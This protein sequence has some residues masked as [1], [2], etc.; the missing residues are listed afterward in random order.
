MVEDDRTDSEADDDA[1]FQLAGEAARRIVRR[2]SAHARITNKALPRYTGEPAASSPFAIDRASALAGKHPAAFAQTAKQV[3]VLSNAMTSH[4]SGLHV[5][6]QHETFHGLPAVVIARSIA[7]AAASCAWILHPGVSS[8]QRA[9]RA[10]AVMFHS[11]KNSASQVLPEDAE[12]AIKMREALVDELAGSGVTV[13][14]REKR[15]KRTDDIAQVTVGDA[16]V[17]TEYVISQRIANEIPKLRGTYGGMSSVAHGEALNVSNVWT[18]PD[19][20][21]RIIGRVAHESVTAWSQALHGWLALEPSPIGNE[22]DLQRLRQSMHPDTIAAI[23]ARSEQT[24]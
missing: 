1:R 9:A 17:K 2:C 13:T 11:L 19:L 22:D 10:Y 8:D 14:R 16:H 7:E 5:L 24:A 3:E 15:G 21:A 18:R 6:I 12:Y 4:L 20:Y 23:K